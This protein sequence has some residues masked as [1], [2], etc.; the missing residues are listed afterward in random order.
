VTRSFGIRCF[1]NRWILPRG[2]R[3]RARLVLRQ[4]LP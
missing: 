4:R 1:R 3:W 2:P